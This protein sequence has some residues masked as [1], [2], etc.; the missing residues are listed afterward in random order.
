MNY[1]KKSIVKLVLLILL[2]PFSIDIL[3]ENILKVASVSVIEGN[4]S[5]IEIQ[6]INSDV[7]VGFQFD[8]TLPNA[9]TI[10]TNTMTLTGRKQDHI[11]I[12][13]SL[14][15]NVFR[16]ISY[17]PSQSPYLLNSG[18]IVT[19]PFFAKGG[20]VGNH[21]ITITNSILGNSSSEN[22]LTGSQNGTL[23]IQSANLAPVANAGIDSQFDEGTTV[24]LDGSASS[25][26]N[27]DYITYSWSA[28]LGITLNSKNVAKPTFIAPEVT[29][30]TNYTFSLIVNDGKL[31]SIADEVVIIIK[32]VNKAPISNAGTN[33]IVNEGDLVTLDGSKSNDPDGDN[34]SYQWSSPAEIVLNS[35]TLSQ[36]AFI[37]P[38]VNVDTQF[39]FSLIVNDGMT[40]SDL[41][42]V[43][44]TVKNK[45]INTNNIPVANAGIDQIVNEGDIVTLDGT[46]SSDADGDKLYYEWTVP[47]N[48]K[49]NSTTNSQ[50]VF[51]APS[52]AEDTQY[53]ISLIINDG[54]INS[55]PDNIVILVKNIPNSSHEQVESSA[56][57]VFPNPVKD[58]FYV[59]GIKQAVTIVLIDICGRTLLSKKI[60]ENEFIPLDKIQNG[61]YIL[62]IGMEGLIKR[63][64]IVYK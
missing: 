20:F 11:L 14:G 47:T 32:N 3:A 33:Q 43:V 53:D 16:F 23:T 21:S 58:G 29:Q 50:P 52:V 60:Y 12:V 7:L 4:S 31:N 49:L 64:I 22:I 44:I 61:V 59:N 26:P 36:P 5:S 38:N 42:D 63:K 8:I 34:L 51:I 48:I 54:K 30:N 28:P 2:M 56:L 62:R 13:S 46:N 57:K 45:D 24:V 17:S 18:N 19:I 10:N 9:I 35:R 40:D 1:Q 15:S 41:D 27:G 39:T 37:A 55:T 25:D 6:I